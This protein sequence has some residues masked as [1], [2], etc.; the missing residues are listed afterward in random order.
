MTE[1]GENATD[2]G[3]KWAF[4]R[5]CAT[6]EPSSERCA[7]TTTKKGEENCTGSEPPNQQKQE[8][9]VE[10]TLEKTDSG[11]WCCHQNIQETK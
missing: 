11:E 7:T 9:Y 1:H 5:N 4:K 2:E 3:Q 10:E 8:H 6:S